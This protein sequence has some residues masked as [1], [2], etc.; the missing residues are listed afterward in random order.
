MK[1][2]LVLTSALLVLTAAAASAQV[3]L[4]WN[5]CITQANQAANL[6]YACDGT[7]D[8]LPAKMVMSFIAPDAPTGPLAAFVGIRALV[9]VQT[10]GAAMPDFWAL[11]AGGCRDGNLST[12]SSFAG[13]GTGATGACQNPYLGGGTTGGDTYVPTSPN[14]ARITVSFVRDTPVPLTANQQYVAAWLGLDFFGDV[15]LGDSHVCPGCDVPACIVLNELD[16]YQT[17][18]TPPQDI[19]ILT[20]AAQRQYITWQGGGIDAPGCPDA[21]PTQNKTWGSVK[22]LYR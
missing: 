18:G 14:R 5:N 16:L 9:D 3:N 6:N 4:A 15:D 21:T 13:I 1:K 20:N 17:A 7:R 10:A 12:G 2:L 11:A 22:S 8:G 19:Y